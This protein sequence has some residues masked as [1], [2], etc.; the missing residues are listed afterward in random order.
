MERWTAAVLRLRW[1][2]LGAWLVALAISS[3]A[4]SGL[5]DLLTNRF[6]LPGA[7]SHR[8]AKI[9]NEHFGQK[10]EGSFTLVAQAPPGAAA[11]LVPRVREAAT[12]AAAELPTGRVSAVRP[13]SDT[14]VSASIVSNVQPAEAKR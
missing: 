8:A 7:E 11:R 2:I 3:V 4:L 13:A 14:I 1:P 12:R 9:L 5:S 10:P 6:V